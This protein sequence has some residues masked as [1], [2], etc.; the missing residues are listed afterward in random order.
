MVYGYLPEWSKCKFNKQIK[1]RL[2]IKKQDLVRVQGKRDR[3][4]QVFSCIDVSRMPCLTQNTDCNLYN[5]EET[6]KW[7]KINEESSEA[8][9]QMYGIILVRSRQ[10]VEDRHGKRITLEGFLC[11]VTGNITP[12][13][14]K[15][16]VSFE[17][18]SRAVKLE[19]FRKNAKRGES[20]SDYNDSE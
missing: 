12:D 2:V 14:K 10:S 1:I 16:I 20:D 7:V 17:E 4:K 15:S 8:M 19:E 11:P 6:S 5:E 18:E 9:E 13:L 3:A